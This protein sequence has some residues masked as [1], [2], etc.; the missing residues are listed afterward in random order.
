MHTVC[1]RV[2]E[3]VGFG[4]L[5]IAEEDHGGAAVVQ[6]LEAWAR[7]LGMCDAPKDAQMV[8]VR[9]ASVDTS[10]LHQYFVS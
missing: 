5:F 10:I 1:H 6:F 3:A 7:H 8:H 9:L 2:K 4:A